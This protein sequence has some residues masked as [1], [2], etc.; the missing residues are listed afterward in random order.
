ML[1]G[2]AV[3]PTSGWFSGAVNRFIE[4]ASTVYEFVLNSLSRGNLDN[5]ELG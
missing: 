2:C 1:L 3:T 5:D 4:L